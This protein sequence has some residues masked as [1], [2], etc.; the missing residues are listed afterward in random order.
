MRSINGFYCLRLNF[1]SEKWTSFERIDD[2]DVGTGFYRGKLREDLKIHKQS[3]FLFS[4]A[5]QNCSSIRLPGFNSLR[6][7]Y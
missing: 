2:M 5:L 6:F 4:G 7:S 1:G 3:S